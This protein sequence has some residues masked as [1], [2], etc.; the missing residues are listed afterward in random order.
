[1][2][3]GSTT[4]VTHYVSSTVNC[5]ADH[6]LPS[7]EVCPLPAPVVHLAGWVDAECHVSVKHQ[8]AV[9]HEALIHRD[10][11]QCS[12]RTLLRLQNVAAQ[13]AMDGWNIHI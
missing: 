9:G 11:A 4:V 5:Y 8:E 1:M 10:R 3:G 6:R 7:S 12:G 13:M 2:R